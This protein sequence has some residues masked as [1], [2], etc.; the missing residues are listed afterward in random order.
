M[1]APPVAVRSASYAARAS[2]SPAQ[3]LTARI[4]LGA[5]LIAVAPC[6]QA[7]LA[8]AWSALDARGDAGAFRP[9]WGAPHLRRE[10][11]AHITDAMRTLLVRAAGYEVK[12]I[13]FV[14]AEH[15][16]KNTLIVAASR[17]TSPR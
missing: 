2:A 12:A 16:R 10:T 4:A 9:I 15:T 11:A 5:E 6:C 17:S 3:R 8:R 13:E 14:P 7:E 1:P